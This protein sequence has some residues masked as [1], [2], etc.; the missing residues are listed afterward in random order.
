MKKAF[1]SIL[2]I[3]FIG[4][5]SA[6]VSPE[7]E[8]E[9]REIEEDEMVEVLVNTKDAEIHESNFSQNLGVEV[10]RDYAELEMAY[11]EMPASSVDNIANR[12]FIERA[13]P[14]YEIEAMLTD[15]RPQIKAGT[16]GTNYTGENVSVA[17]IDSGVA[18]HQYLDIY[19]QVDFTG[20]GVGDLN[21]HGTHV[22]GIVASN[23]PD[24][25]GI[26]PESEL[27]DLKVLGE[28][29]SGQA[30]YMLRSVDYVIS[31]DIDVAVMSLGSRLDRCNGNDV[32]SRSVDIASDRGSVVVAAAG[33]DGPGS[34]TITSPGCSRSAITVGSV[35]KQDNIATYSSK[36]LTADERVKPDVVAPGSNIGSTSRTGGLVRMSGTS[37]AAPHVAGQSAI[38]LST[39]LEPEEVKPVIMESSEDIDAEENSQGHGRIDI[40]ASLEEIGERPSFERQDISRWD[41]FKNWFLSLLLF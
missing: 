31:N 11:L 15:S 23:H 13:E 16:S 26:A 17:V 32:L 20:E 41:R 40:E 24:Y 7:L 8:E 35:D 18:E 10:H 19:E 38:L 37:M 30:S 29:G 14:N 33:N 34:Q 9:L 3:L 4:L 27:Y 21:G 25:R 5:V 39:G 22:A 12:S 36:G 2:L 6:D 28:D 1:L